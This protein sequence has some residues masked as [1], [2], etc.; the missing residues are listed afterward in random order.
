LN[1]AEIVGFTTFFYKK[2]LRNF[3]FKLIFR[4]TTGGRRGCNNEKMS[5]FM[6]SF[7]GGMVRGEKM[8]ITIKM[9]MV[10]SFWKYFYGRKKGV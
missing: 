2:H 6:L 1:E 10:M 3:L 9:G 5:F 4:I 8:V 7:F